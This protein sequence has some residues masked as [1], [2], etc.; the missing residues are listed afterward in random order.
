MNNQRAKE[1]MERD[2]F[3]ALIASSPENVFYTTGFPTTPHAW[4]RI[5]FLLRNESPVLA[6]ITPDRPPNLVLKKSGLAVAKIYANT[7][8]FSTYASQDAGVTGDVETTISGTSSVK[9]LANSLHERSVSKATIGVEESMPSFLL[10]KLRSLLPSARFLYANKLFFE[11]RMV[12][13]GSEVEKLR[14]ATEKCENALQTAM[15]FIK[16]GVTERAIQNAFKK[17][18]V[19]NG[20]D[21]TNTK[22][23]AGPLSHTFSHQGT[24]YKVRKGDII[25]FNVGAAHEGYICDVARVAV[26]GGQL[27]PESRRIFETLR[28]AQRASIKKLRPRIP[29]GEVFNT[30][31]KFVREAGYPNYSRDFVGHGVGVELHEEPL[32]SDKRSWVLEPNTVFTVEVPNYDAALGGFNNEDMIHMTENGYEELSNLSRD[33][34]VVG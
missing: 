12:K 31:V 14:K 23:A 10:D 25:L 3:D 5:F 27:K 22:V 28:D 9:A 34:H 30:A 4:N 8:D 32:L 24:D 13:T 1:L 29:V 21:W 6:A 18:L 20:A 17:H 7:E 33:I 11:I 2:G 26:L 15:S 19:E 16:E